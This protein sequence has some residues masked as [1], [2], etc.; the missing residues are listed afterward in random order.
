MSDAGAPISY[1]VLAE[2]TPVVARDGTEAGTVKRVLAD[3]GAD[4]FDELVLD[5]PGGDRFV[6]ADHAGELFER[7]VVLDLSG[8][9]LEHLPEATANPA[10]VGLDPDDLGD[11][12][13]GDGLR[14]TLRRAWD[15]ISGNY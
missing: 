6:D 8:E 7:Q 13:P 12:G 4:I 15:R 5:T 2:G 1:L 14:D 3:E 9:E 11:D 10:T